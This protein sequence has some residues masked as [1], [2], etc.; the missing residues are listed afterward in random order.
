M[1]ICS[2]KTKC[3][4]CCATGEIETDGNIAWFELDEEQNNAQLH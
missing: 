1:A 3:L 2:D 4:N